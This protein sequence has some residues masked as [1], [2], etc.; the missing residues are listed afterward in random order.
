MDDI[1]LKIFS[2]QWRGVL[3]VSAVLLLAAEVGFRLGH[4][5][6]RSNDEARK[7]QIGGVQNAMLGVLGLLLGFTFAMVLGLYQIRRDLTLQEA[8]SIGTTFLR[9]SLLPETHRAC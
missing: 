3:I 5:L 1:L 2:N 6:Y 9:A 8:N 7:W 4:R